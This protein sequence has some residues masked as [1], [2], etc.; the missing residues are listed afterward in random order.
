MC[1]AAAGE[2]TGA[3][4]TNALSSLN[5]GVT[6]FNMFMQM[7]DKSYDSPQ[8]RV[9]REA[10]FLENMQMIDVTTDTPRRGQVY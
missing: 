2:L 9:Q 10:M 8:E 3:A 5:N 4:L 6:N 7:F 1:L